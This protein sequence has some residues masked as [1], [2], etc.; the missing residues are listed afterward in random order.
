MR[1][2]C[3]LTTL[4]AATFALAACELDFRCTS[5]CGSGPTE[6]ER[7]NYLITGF[8]YARVH[9]RILRLTVGD[10]MTVYF[11]Q[12][13]SWPPVGQLDTLR[14]VAWSTT[15]PAIAVSSAGL[16]RAQRSGSATP[17]VN[18][19]QYP[20]WARDSTGAVVQWTLVKQIVVE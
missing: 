5:N 14:D 3:G 12:V 6:N 10:T 18:G 13:Y 2:S 17:L 8:P 4:L 9:D 19:S 7:P 16:L 1:R 11:G 15:G 20:M